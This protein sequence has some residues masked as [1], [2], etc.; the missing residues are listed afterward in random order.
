MPRIELNGTRFHYQ[1][2]GE[3][4]D[5]VLIHGLSSNIAFWWGAI[6]PRLAQH[7]RVTAVDLKGHGFSGMTERGYGAAN[8][9]QDV[10]HLLDH[11]GIT[12]AALVGHSYGGAIA[13]AVAVGQGRRVAHLTLADAWVPSL[14][15]QFHSPNPRAWAALRRRL[16][17]RGIH[18]ESDMPR[19]MMAFLEELVDMPEGETGAREALQRFA[20]WQPG[21][22]APHGMRKWRRLMASTHA[23][24]EVNQTTDLE[25][26]RIAA[27]PMPVTVIYGQRS[28]YTQTRDALRRLLPKARCLDVQGGH[29]FPVMRPDML[30]NAIVED[31][32]VIDRAVALDAPASRA[33]EQE[34]E[35]EGYMNG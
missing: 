10:L 2:M 29:Y 16:S 18:I 17:L 32:A 13:L 7:F 11:L 5:I 3:G 33:I 12:R 28:R 30:T 22:P 15:E 25:P 23:W 14:Q 27:L 26:E 21:Q 35:E 31:A 20:D 8:L 34:P 19:V 1:Q 4:S 9:G 24:K 6:A